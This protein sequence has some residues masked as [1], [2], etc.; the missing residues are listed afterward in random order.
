MI[1]VGTMIRIPKPWTRDRE[2]DNDGGN[3]DTRKK[4]IPVLETN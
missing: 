3:V 1:I 2:W 4:A